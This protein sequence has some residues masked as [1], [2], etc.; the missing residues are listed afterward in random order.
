MKVIAAIFAILGIAISGVM[1]IIVYQSWTA[2]KATPE[3]KLAIAMTE[4]AA[5]NDPKAK[6]VLDD[7]HEAQLKLYALCATPIVGLVALV[8]VMKSLGSFPDYSSWWRGSAHM[9]FFHSR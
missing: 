6:K 2:L 9:R 7:V 3:Y 4:E 8:L 5:K 1:A